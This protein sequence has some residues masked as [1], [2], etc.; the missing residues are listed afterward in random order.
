MYVKSRESGSR[1]DCYYNR[2]SYNNEERGHLAIEDG[3]VMCD[4]QA[5]ALSV[6]LSGGSLF[7]SVSGSAYLPI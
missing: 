6:A 5:P 2:K 4:R 1:I 7:L 3:K